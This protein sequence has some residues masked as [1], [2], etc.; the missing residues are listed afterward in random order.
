MVWYLPSLML[1][2]AEDRAFMAPYAF[3]KLLRAVSVR[4]KSRLSGLYLTGLFKKITHG[5]RLNTFG[6]SRRQLLF[7]YSFRRLFQRSCF[8]S[9][10]AFP[11]TTRPY[12]ALVR[13]TFSRRGSFRKP[14][15]DASLLLTQE[16]RIKSFSL[17]WKLSTEATSIS[18]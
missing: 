7:L 17:P 8:E 12:L 13:A 11:K 9:T 1:L 3:S 4:T 5:L 6:P 2:G 18:L 14:I 10:L 15:P 16:R